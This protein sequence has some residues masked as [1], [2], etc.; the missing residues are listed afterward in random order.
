MALAAVS[1]LWEL[2]SALPLLRR[3]WSHLKLMLHRVLA[4]HLESPGKWHRSFIS[5]FYH[6][7]AQNL[8]LGMWLPLYLGAKGP[9]VPLSV[10][11]ILLMFLV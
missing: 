4:G 8:L 6:G 2:R 5:C 1:P 10:Q 3:S 9:S 7:I 11:E